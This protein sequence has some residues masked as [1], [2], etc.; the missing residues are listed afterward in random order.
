MSLY[1]VD[2]VMYVVLSEAKNHMAYG[3]LVGRHQLKCDGTQ[4]HRGAEVK[5]KLAKAV[6]SQYPSHYL[7]TR[8]IQHYYR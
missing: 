5:R 4:C 2:A 3:E 7:G 1:L 8:C 6:G